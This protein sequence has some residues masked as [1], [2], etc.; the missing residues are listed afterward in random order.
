MSLKADTG[1]DES[2]ESIVCLPDI[3]SKLCKSESEVLSLDFR[4]ILPFLR[5]P[6][7]LDLR[8]REEKME[9]ISILGSLEILPD[10]YILSFKPKGNGVCNFL[11]QL[12][13]AINLAFDLKLLVA[14]SSYKICSTGC[15]VKCLMSCPSFRKC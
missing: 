8:I 12:S 14:L 7:D 4:L 15:T 2:R 6:C 9:N 11:I 5:I 3:K 10:W 13:S 1:N